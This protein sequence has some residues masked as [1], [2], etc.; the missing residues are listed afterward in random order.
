MFE[1]PGRKIKAVA[2]LFFVLGCIPFVVLGILVLVNPN[3]RGYCIL[4]WV[5]GPFFSYVF[6]LLIYGFG[7]LVENSA[8]APHDTG[9]AVGKVIAAEKAKP[10]YNIPK[11]DHAAAPKQAP[12]P[13]KEEKKP[14]PSVPNKTAELNDHLVYALQYHMDDGMM[15]YLNSVREKLSKEEQQALFTIF[16]APDGKLRTAIT[17]YLNGRSS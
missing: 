1:D 8:S 4:F 5:L 15:R 14:V 13:V 7:E 12:N 10:V 17:D 16:T 2:K 6:A 11:A 3:T 9:L